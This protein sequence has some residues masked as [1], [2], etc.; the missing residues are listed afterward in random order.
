LFTSAIPKLRPFILLAGASLV[1]SMLACQVDLGGPDIPSVPAQTSQQAADSL[2][3]QW[4]ALALQAEASDGQ[5]RLIV[6]EQQLTS[7]LHSR[8]SQEA[9]AVLLQPTVQLSDGAI[10]LFGTVEQDW[11]KARV[12]VEIQVAVS[13]EGQ[14]SFDITSAEFGPLPLP[15][16]IKNSIEGLIGEAFSGSIGPYLTGIQLETVAIADGEMALIGTL[17]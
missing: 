10:R 8:L 16:P 1:L 14:P 3:Q 7:F 2:E 6:T 13:P 11:A 12:L 4:Q 17:R 15:E 5:V 9:D